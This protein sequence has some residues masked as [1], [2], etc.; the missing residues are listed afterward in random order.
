MKNSHKKMIWVLVGGLFWV[1][2]SS[3]MMDSPSQNF[4]LLQKG[5]FRG[6]SSKS[7]F[8]SNDDGPRSSTKGSRSSSRD[9]LNKAA[10]DAP[11]PNYSLRARF[12]KLEEL[13]K[14]PDFEGASF[15]CSD[16]CHELFKRN[17]HE[18]NVFGYVFKD[19]NLLLM[20]SRTAPSALKEL[21]SVR[22]RID[23]EDFHTLFEPT[24]SPEEQLCRDR[25]KAKAYRQAV[26]ETEKANS[27][28]RSLS[29]QRSVEICDFS[30]LESFIGSLQDSMRRHRNSSSENADI[31][32][33]IAHV[34]SLVD[35]IQQI[36]PL[37]ARK[38]I[39]H[40]FSR[41][42]H[43]NASSDPAEI[44]FHVQPHV[45]EIIHWGET[46]RSVSRKDRPQE[47]LM[48]SLMRIK[49]YFGMAFPDEIS[50]RI[51][52]QKIVCR[53][54]DFLGYLDLFFSMTPEENSHL[55]ALLEAVSTFSLEIYDR[56]K[57][58]PIKGRKLNDAFVGICEAVLRSY[59]AGDGNI[60]GRINWTF[61]A[62]IKMLNKEFPHT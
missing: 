60:L 7:S 19:L 4:E 15:Y 24:L 54:D 41:V 39:A 47:D 32:L 3:A 11:L 58:T 9:S 46:L 51:A 10:T 33:Y 55:Y 6:Q 59:V 14:K 25:Q 16:N 57:G 21:Q 45:E 8:S 49:N 31:G 48:M 52:E 13:L 17:T 42:Q 27:A 61:L 50:V 20:S 53:R 43:L 18:S 12:N 5:M 62:Y 30:F 29:I 37:V 38:H 1:S 36:K 56:E 35:M 22:S 23:E 26:M 40:T 44:S 34:Q 2:S 28:A